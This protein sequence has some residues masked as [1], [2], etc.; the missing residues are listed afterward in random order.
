MKDKKVE[1][2]IYECPVCGA[3]VER[4]VTRGVVC[5]ECNV[6]MDR[7]IKSNAFEDTDASMEA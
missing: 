4:S 2:H 7:V 5:V 3:V 6:F 1:Q